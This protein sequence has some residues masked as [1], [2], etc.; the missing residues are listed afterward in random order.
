MNSALVSDMRA[1]IHTNRIPLS[2][3]HLCGCYT[4][5]VHRL[6]RAWVLAH[7]ELCATAVG[8]CWW[9]DG[10]P[11]QK[12]ACENQAFSESG[13]LTSVSATW[14]IHECDTIHGICSY[15]S[16]DASFKCVI[17]SSHSRV[18][19]FL[20]EIHLSFPLC[21]C[22]YL[23]LYGHALSLTHKQWRISAYELT[24]NQKKWRISMLWCWLLFVALWHGRMWKWE[25]WRQFRLW[26]NVFCPQRLHTFMRGCNGAYDILNNSRSIA[27]RHVCVCVCARAKAR[28]RS[29]ASV[30][31][32]VCD[33]MRRVTHWRIVSHGD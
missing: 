9:N 27:C 28:A 1:G 32:C 26:Q 7:V 31:A 16:F 22:W 25:W 24:H 30:C 20:H 29:P 2:L 19:L 4:F 8:C 13:M 18:G 6:T 10:C 12:Q 17:G 23:C 14:L 21:I 33:C 3:C 11:N 5:V 15:I